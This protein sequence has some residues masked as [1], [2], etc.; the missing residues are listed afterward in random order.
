MSS[1]PDP[2]FQVALGRSGTTVAMKLFAAHPDVVAHMAYPLELRAYALALHPDDEGLMNGARHYRDLAPF[3][4]AD[5]SAIDAGRGP[6]VEAVRD[7][8]R[9][10]AANQGKASPRYATEK[11]PPRLDLAAARAQAPGLKAL[12]LVRDPRDVLSSARAFDEKRGYRGFVEREGDTEEA[13]VARYAGLYARLLDL[14]SATPDGILVR[15]EDLI[16]EPAREARRVFTWLGLDASDEVVDAAVAA[17][18]AKKPGRHLTAASVPE[19]VGRWREALSPQ[20]ADLISQRLAAPLAAF[21]Y[22]A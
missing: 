12:F 22:P 20:L 3:T 17:A 16:T 1:A 8:Y 4:E 5:R 15:Y 18:T 10:M 13:V 14:H 19:T 11:Y 7:L 6:D 21:G 9:R 2:F